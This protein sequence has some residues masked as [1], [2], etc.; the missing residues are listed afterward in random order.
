MTV[1]GSR[2]KN[3]FNVPKEYEINGVKTQSNNGNARYYLL[4]DSVTGDITI[5]TA[6]GQLPSSVG[7][8]TDM[9]RVVGTIPKD[10]VF[11]P[12]VG[13]TTSQETQY[14]NSAVGQKAVK[15][16]A[17]T[18]AQKAGAQ[19]AHQL[20]FPNSATPGAGQGQN[21][22]IPGVAPGA[23]GANQG[24]T[25]AAAAEEAKSFKKGTRKGEGSYDTN[26]KYPINLKSEVQDVIKFSILEYSPSLAK[27]NQG[28]DNFGSTKS[29]VVTLE[30]NNP[31]VKGSKKIG[32]ITLPIPAG[33]SDGNTVGWQTDE[34]ND[35]QKAAA[36]AANIF[37]SGG[38]AEQSG[39]PLTGLAQQGASPEGAD[40]VRGIFTGMAVGNQKLMQR[41]QGAVLNNNIE[42]LF[43]GPGLRQFS[44]QFLFYPREPKEAIMVRKIIRAFKQAM[45]VKRSATS[46]LLKSPHTFAIQYMTS[47]GGKTVAHPY[48]N[49]F[50]ECAL[51]SCSVDYTPDGTYMTYSSR[52]NPDGDEKS[53]T[54]YRLSLSF[55]ELEP[56][57]DDE[58]NEI[59][60]NK[61]L[62]IGF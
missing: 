3:P 34:I 61:D 43:S 19:N 1:Y 30:G 48:L 14:F 4:V 22:P 50:K 36:D 51:T 54:A 57:F 12:V 58:Y 41:T 45:S 24:S 37:L 60:G 38:T 9:D 5:K 49:R 28:A 55:Q 13:S 18:T 29:R 23:P 17:V 16:H 42:L 56:L 33:I 52:G 44:F 39:A 10:G 31:V 27:E 8:N 26:M 32:T 21:A 11:K 40:A 2:D 25:V 15:N 53:M 47:I 7:G 62:E 20:I 35:L 46:L 6:D 59:D